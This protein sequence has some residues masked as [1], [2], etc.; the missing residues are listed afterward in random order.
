MVMFDATYE[1]LNDGWLDCEEGEVEVSVHGTDMCEVG[2]DSLGLHFA[3]EAGNPSYD[4]WLRGGEE[5]A[6]C[7]VESVDVKTH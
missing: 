6:I 1:V 7:V 3:S 4:G 5:W 2:L